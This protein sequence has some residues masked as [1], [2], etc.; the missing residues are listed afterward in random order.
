[1][2]VCMA[3]RGWC[4]VCARV[5]QFSERF[6]SEGPGTCGGDL[7]IGLTLMNQYRKQCVALEARRAD[8]TAAE[9]LFDLPISVCTLPVCVLSVALLTTQS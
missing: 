1:M 4:D 5:Q 2:Y 8:L 7:D 6:V 3:E 9:K